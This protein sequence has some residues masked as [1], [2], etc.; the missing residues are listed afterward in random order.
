MNRSRVK[1]MLL[2][3]ISLIITAQAF[4]QTKLFTK[5]DNLKNIG[6]KT[7]MVVTDNNS[8]INLSI[9]EA[10]SK[11]WDLCKVD[12]CNMKEFEQMC[13]DSS[14]FFLVKVAGQF[15]KEDDPGIEFL[16]LL[17]GGSE[18]AM[19]IGNMYEILSLPLQPVDDGE[20]YILP[21]MDI[22]MSIFKSH[23]RR[24]QDSKI[25][26]TVG[27]SW[28]GNRIAKIGKKSVLINED[29]MSE[30]ITADYINDSF[31]DN[32]KV[33]D[34]D[35]ILSTIEKK[36]KDMLVSICIAPEEPQNNGSYCYKMLV[37]VD[38]GELYYFRKQKITA[39]NPKGFLP[40]DIKKIS[41]PFI[42]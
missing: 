5:K 39:K 14:Y 18:A 28:Y 11:N 22:Y 41:I 2:T 3:V 21:F 13:E 19:G 38:D 35:F 40:E 36:R 8:L 10:A 42:F 31:K 15:K 25:A 30:M 27:L 7:L 23:V 16:S 33:V 17:K 26:N 20:G 9:K 12:F 24:V 29:D 32:G 4:A 1:I 34:E 37:G 6:E